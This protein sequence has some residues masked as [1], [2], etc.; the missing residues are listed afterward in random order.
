MR[1]LVTAALAG[2]LALAAGAAVAVAGSSDV[3][4]AGSRSPSG[5]RGP[6]GSGGADG[7]LV[8]LSGRDDHGLLASA[9]VALRARPAGDGTPV[10]R[11]ADGTL[12]RVVSTDGTWLEVRTVE[13]QPAQGWVD[14]FYLRGGVHLIGPPPTCRVPFN[15]QLLADGEQAVVLDVRGKQAQVRVTRTGQTGWVERSTVREWSPEQGCGQ[16]DSPEPADGHHHGG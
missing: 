6:A 2:V 1:P 14:D 8:L 7:R 11:V 4:H 9:Q 15:G 3:S 5:S 12:A 16:S 13:G 10:A